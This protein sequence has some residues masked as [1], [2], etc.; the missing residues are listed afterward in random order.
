MRSLVFVLALSVAGALAAETLAAETREKNHYPDPVFLSTES[1]GRVALMPPVPARHSATDRADY[2]EIL[3]QQ[4]SRTPEDVKRAAAV[5]DVK[6]ATLFGKPYGPLTAA[7][8]ERWS[9]FFT[10]VQ[11]DTD[12]WV[13][14]TKKLNR[15]LRPYQADKRVQPAVY[16]EWTRAYPSGHA[17]ISRIFARVL[18]KLDPAREAA[19]M[20][21][22]EQ[23]ASDR[24]L[25]GVHHPSDLAAGKA[26]AEKVLVALWSNPAFR[27]E[28]GRLQREK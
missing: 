2:A 9:P 14:E 11:W 15:R 12:Y 1:L 4:S 3:R 10:R 25:A 23:I 16:K 8:V 22:A 13:Q 27:R 28:F 17:A 18:A 26:L 6:L 20:A 19:F 21:R 7:E 24:V 5:V